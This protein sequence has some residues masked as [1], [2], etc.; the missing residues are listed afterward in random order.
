MRDQNR[1][2]LIHKV[3]KK[4]DSMTRNFN[5]LMSKDTL[6]NFRA[7]NLGH[8]NVWDGKKLSFEQGKSSACDPDKQ[9]KLKGQVT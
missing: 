2:I 3:K 1:R 8:L 9:N 7:G 6:V 4:K 5:S